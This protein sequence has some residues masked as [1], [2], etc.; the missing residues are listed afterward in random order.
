MPQPAWH[1]GFKT[2]YDL[3]GSSGRAGLAA[4]VLQKWSTVI[5]LESSIGGNFVSE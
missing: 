4:V 1:T 3:T 2:F 5:S